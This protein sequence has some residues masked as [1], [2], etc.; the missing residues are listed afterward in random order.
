MGADR[1]D[2]VNTE[3]DVT[4]ACNG[5]YIHARFWSNYPKEIQDSA[6]S[7]MLRCQ[8]GKRGHG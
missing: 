6:T 8:R 5:S 3:P 1:C 2:P 7:Q 4:W